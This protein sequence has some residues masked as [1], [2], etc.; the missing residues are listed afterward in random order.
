MMVGCS[1]IQSEISTLFFWMGTPYLVQMGQNRSIESSMYKRSEKTY[2]TYVQCTNQPNCTKPLSKTA[3]IYGEILICRIDLHSHGFPFNI[4]DNNGRRVQPGR[5]YHTECN[6]KGVQEIMHNF[7]TNFQ[8][9]RFFSST[10]Y[11]IS[12]LCIISSTPFT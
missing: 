8:Q 12:K 3:Q 9:G 4:F 11:K 5:E 6:L 2:E 7:E 1:V 10:H